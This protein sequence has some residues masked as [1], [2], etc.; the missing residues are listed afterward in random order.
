M[1][2]TVEFALTSYLLGI[3]SFAAGFAGHE[4]FG[5]SDFVKTGFPLI[6]LGVG[7]YNSRQFVAVI[8]STVAL[9]LS[10]VA[11]SKGALTSR[12]AWPKWWLHTA[13]AG[14]H[15]GMASVMYGRWRASD[16]V[17]CGVFLC[18]FYGP[19][20]KAN[21]TPNG[22]YQREWI[23]QTVATCTNTWMTFSDIHTNAVLLPFPCTVPFSNRPSFSS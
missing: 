23:A 12:L 7:G 13:L 4:Y 2:V 8:I 10:S 14:I 21:D 5:S 9:P 19:D 17:N 18:A 22:Y 3:A 15:I 1:S 11:L 20:G 6:A 16:L